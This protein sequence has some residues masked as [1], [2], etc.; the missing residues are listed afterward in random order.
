MS[1]PTYPGMSEISVYLHFENC[2]FALE[3]LERVFG[4]TETLR[5]PIPGGV[6]AHAEMKSGDAIL[7]LGWPGPEYRDPGLERAESLGVVVYVPD[8]D[9]HFRR[10]ER[11][12]AVIDSPLK[13]QPYGDR[14]YRVRDYA[15][16]LW[17]F[18]THT[19]DVDPSEWGG[20]L[21]PSAV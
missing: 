9:A 12:G 4:F 1:T 8:V 17:T 20:V 15:G 7:M 2:S 3:W 11:A 18:A 10:A 14:T 16:H 21:P 13:D 19:R 6:V 5:V